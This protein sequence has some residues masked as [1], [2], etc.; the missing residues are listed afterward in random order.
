MIITLCGKGGVG[1]TTIS[2]MILDEL[3]RAGYSG[4]V[5]AVDG[6]PAST[7]AMSLGL[8]T[9]EVTIAD[10]RDNLQ[11]DAKTVRGFPAGMSPAAYVHKQIKETGVLNSYQLYDMPLDLITMGQS[12]GAGC[13]CSVNNALSL[14]LKKLIN[15]Y[16]LILIDNEAG[17]EHISRYRLERADLFL[18]VSTPHPKARSV[19]QRIMETAHGVNITIGESLVVFNQT[20]P[21]FQPEQNG[22]PTMPLAIP[23]STALAEIEAMGKPVS[24]LPAGDLVRQ[25]LRPILARI[26]GKP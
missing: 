1:K 25:A 3:A 19:A 15:R 6:D 18:V 17:L 2:A 9:A 24:E 21:G 10:I 4:P 20:P 8:P 12:E 16:A 13:Y 11:L 14:V 23:L 26:T 22:Y 5:L 7:L